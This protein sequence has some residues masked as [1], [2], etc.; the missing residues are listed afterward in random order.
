MRKA[1]AFFLSVSIF[2]SVAVPAGYAATAERTSSVVNLGDGITVE[3]NLTVH[4]SILRNNTKRA[5]RESVYK[6]NGT[7]IATVTLDATFGYDGTT[8]WVVSASASCSV[9]S[10]WSYESE[11]ISTTGATARVTATLK[12]WLLFISVLSVPVDISLKCSPTGTIS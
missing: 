8:A 12:K 2:L 9:V 1:I 3:T 4:P 11:S 5:T 7:T 6:D 10:G